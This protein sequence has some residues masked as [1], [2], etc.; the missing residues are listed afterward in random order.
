MLGINGVTILVT[1]SKMAVRI[2]QIVN[3][4]YQYKI[5]DEHHKNE[6]RKKLAIFENLQL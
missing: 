4:A 1:F 3:Q 5:Y 6:T 2:H